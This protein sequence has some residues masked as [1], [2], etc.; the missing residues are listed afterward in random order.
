VNWGF[1]SRGWERSSLNLWRGS[2]S[3]LL[4]ELS[5]SL[6]CAEALALVVTEEVTGSA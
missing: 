6:S 1:G 3:L 5:V 4:I 2:T